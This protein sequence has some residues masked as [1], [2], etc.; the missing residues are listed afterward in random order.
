MSDDGPGRGIVLLALDKAHSDDRKG[1]RNSY[2]YYAVSAQ[3]VH[4]PLPSCC[5]RVAI[6]PEIRP[7]ICPTV[8]PV[9]K[10]SKWNILG[11]RT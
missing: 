2:M 1:Q 6:D 3:E 10:K 5:S 7:A 11:E 9:S 4:E 8:K